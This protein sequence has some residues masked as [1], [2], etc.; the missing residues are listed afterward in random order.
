[1]KNWNSILERTNIAMSWHFF[2]LFHDFILTYSID[3]EKKLLGNQRNCSLR[4]MVL[5][6]IWEQ[7]SIESSS[8]RWSEKE[9][10][11]GTFVRINNFILLSDGYIEFSIS[12]PLMAIKR[13]ISWRK[14]EEEKNSRFSSWEWKET[15]TISQNIKMRDKSK[16]IFIA[17]LPCFSSLFHT[18]S[19]SPSF[20][21]H[22]KSKSCNETLLHDVDDGTK[23]R[24]SSL[25][26]CR[27]TPIIFF[28]CWNLYFHLQLKGWKKS[29][30][31][32]KFPFLKGWETRRKKGNPRRNE[33]CLFVAAQRTHFHI[34]LVFFWQ[35]RNP[36][37]FFLFSPC[38]DWRNEWNENL[39]VQPKQFNLKT[40][41]SSQ[42]ICRLVEENL[43]L[44]C[45]NKNFWK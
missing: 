38:V 31:F 24:V 39:Q 44:F 5:W 32:E 37:K 13:E 12:S 19:C 26:L 18:L 35:F 15:E 9:T 7:W 23:T 40:F 33:N 25:E 27:F 42:H 4:E 29:E 20:L 16:W 10:R 34:L 1:M 28:H 36:K 14:N 8:W 3:I 45:R 41:K 22:F 21:L 6:E 30:K 11:A 43:K 17:H 2:H